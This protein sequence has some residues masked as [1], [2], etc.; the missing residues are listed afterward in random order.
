M[1][2]TSSFITCINNDQTND[3]NL[4]L[5]V[6]LLK[7]VELPSSQCCSAIETHGNFGRLLR[8]VI[9]TLPQFTLGGHPIV[10]IP[11]HRDESRLLVIML[12]VLC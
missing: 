2:Y 3:S 4:A 6:T 9:A 7:N 12:Y 5:D 1:Y 11:P 10:A 8:S